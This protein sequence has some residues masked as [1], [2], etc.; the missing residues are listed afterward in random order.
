MRHQAGFSIIEAIIAIVILGFGILAATKMQL[1]MSIASQLSRQRAEATLIATNEIERARA[2]G[3][4]ALSETQ[5][6]AAAQ[7]SAQYKMQIDCSSGM[8]VTVRWQDVQTKAGD[9]E[10]QVVLVSQF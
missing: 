7:A 9:D 5:L 10:N 2:M 8:T 3:C 4:T 1:N 6:D